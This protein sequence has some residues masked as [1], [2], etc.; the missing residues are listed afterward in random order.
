MRFRLLLPALL[1]GALAGCDSLLQTEPSD[2]IPSG[3][4]IKDAPTAHAA[5]IGAY[6]ALQDLSYYG[7][8]FVVLGDMSADN[9]DHVGTYQFLDAIYRHETRADNS[10][11]TG[12]W[13]AIYESIA[14][15]NAI[16]AQLPE[17]TEIDE[18][19]RN[20]ILGEAYFLRALNYHNLVKLWGDVPMP[21]KP[22][23]SPEEAAAYTRAPVADVYQQI[24][25]DLN[26]AGSL[27]TDESQTRQASLGAV[28]ALRARVDLYMGDWEGAEKN[29]D[30][31]YEMGYTLAP[32]Y[33]SLFSPEGTDTPE[34]IFR[35]SFTAV[36]YN[37]VGYYYLWDGRN[38]V[39]PTESIYEAF[40]DGDVRR[41]WSVRE[42]DGYFEGTKFPTTVGAEDLHV[43]RLGEVIL[44]KAEAL[45]Q[46]DR[47]EEAV[48]EYNKL[49]VR[50]GLDPHVFGTDVS[51]K[52]DVLQAIWHERRVE[53]AFEGDRWPDLVRTGQ[54]VSV[55]GLPPEQAYQTLYPIPARE[56]TV[57]PGLTQNPGY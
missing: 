41:D 4:L 31:V 9:A 47:L 48:D 19:E 50:A 27:I 57:A 8:D 16:I 17:V 45:A 38:E 52:D 15:D 35:L 5:L 46:Q 22:A 2:L 7:N 30:S 24:L 54:A 32:S 44:I 18:D 28:R 23:E 55:L 37:E 25:S 21:L 40:E 56:R 42:D 51:T 36:D 10:A 1:V 43:I 11:I 3:S 49:R 12:L 53:L 29:A 26:Q 39:D 13:Q 34:D 33:S 20:E 14:R 6:D